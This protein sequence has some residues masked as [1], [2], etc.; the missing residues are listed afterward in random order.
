MFYISVSFYYLGEEY[1]VKEMESNYFRVVL[2][3]RE[4]LGNDGILY[5]PRVCSGVLFVILFGGC[6]RNCC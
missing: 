6:C 5:C 1:R 4:L 3:L 2:S